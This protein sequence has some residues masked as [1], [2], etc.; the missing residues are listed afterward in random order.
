[1]I[2]G[3]MF[4]LKTPNF[5]V[6]ALKIFI[7]NMIEIKESQNNFTDFISLLKQRG[8]TYRRF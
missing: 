7:I 5:N 8:E 4:K 3:I 2:G 1:M 6:T